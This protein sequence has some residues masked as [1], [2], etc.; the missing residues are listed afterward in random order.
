LVQAELASKTSDMRDRAPT[1]CLAPEHSRQH[2]LGYH[3]GM[4]KLEAT[5]ALPDYSSEE[6]NRRTLGIATQLGWTLDG[7]NPSTRVVRRT[8]PSS[9]ARAAALRELAVQINDPTNGVS[10]GTFVDDF[11]D[12]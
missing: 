4:P 10:V 5:F 3:R 1:N 12:E 6:D 8:F 7:Q 2:H 9:E 11:S